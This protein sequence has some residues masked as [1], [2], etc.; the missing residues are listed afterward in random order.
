MTVHKKAV[1]LLCFFVV[2]SAVW[3]VVAMTTGFGAWVLVPV[4]AVFLYFAVS[5][6][7]LRCPRCGKS[8]YLKTV[9]LFGTGWTYTGGFPETRCSRCGFQLNRATEPL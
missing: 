3:G 7:S 4:L 5:S 2:N 9:R 6:M 1:I 8:I